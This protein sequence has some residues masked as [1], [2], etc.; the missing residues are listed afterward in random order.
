MGRVLS[1][2]VSSLK[3]KKKTQK[4]ALVSYFDA[5]SSCFWSSVCYSCHILNLSKTPSSLFCKI[6]FI[7]GVSVLDLYQTYCCSLFFELFGFLLS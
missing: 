3:K 7:P 2:S 1:E 6:E 5:F 4:T